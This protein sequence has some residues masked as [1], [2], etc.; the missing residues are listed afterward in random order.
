MID[1]KGFS[2]LEVLLALILL[3]TAALALLKQQN[4]TRQLLP[5]LALQA[6]ASQ[7]LDQMDE[8]INKLPTPPAPYHLEVRMNQHINHS[9][10]DSKFTNADLDR[11]IP[12]TARDL[13]RHHAQAPQDEVCGRNGSQSPNAAF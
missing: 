7:V 13:L 8:S 6:Q 1:Q 10:Q 11:L 4:L 9:R 3:T 5:Q 12:S 2:L